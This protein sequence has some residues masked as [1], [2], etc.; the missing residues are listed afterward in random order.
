[1]STKRLSRSVSFAIVLCV[2]V[3]CETQPVNNS[4][5]VQANEQSTVLA[6]D[7][8]LEFPDG[9]TLDLGSGWENA[10]VKCQFRIRNSGRKTI[11]FR[12][13]V[14]T[15]CGCTD[16]TLSKPQLP[17]GETTMLN[18]TIALPSSAGSQKRYFATVHRV[19]DD[20][21][22]GNIGFAVDVIT[23]AAW[24]FVPE[25]VTYRLTEGQSRSIS[26]NVF[27]SENRHSRIIGATS[28]IP[29]AVVTFGSGKLDPLVAQQVLCDVPPNTPAGKYEIIVESDDDIVKKRLVAIE[30]L[31]L[32]K[33][34]ILP[35]SVFLRRV[36]GST[37]Y[38]AKMTVI[39]PKLAA[40]INCIVPEGLR[41]SIGEP[42]DFEGGRQMSVVNLSYEGIPERVADR[43]LVVTVD[44]PDEPPISCEVPLRIQ[45]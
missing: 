36:K 32:V 39:S 4:V 21:T 9:R 3:G 44:V 29:D 8:G 23:N 43:N 19:L 42:H 25:S 27:G 14:T 22:L 12:K 17:P 11:D 6:A 16:G 1:M 7:F 20:G 5:E 37:L 35:Q 31:R 26:L 33:V 38:T 34:E 40:S 24:Y 10:E 15:T 41:Y 45:D 2:A 18:L 30:L 28:T 13:A